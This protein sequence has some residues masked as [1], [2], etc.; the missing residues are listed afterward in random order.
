MSP[1]TAFRLCIWAFTTRGAL[2]LAV[3]FAMPATTFAFQAVA[4]SQ[5]PRGPDLVLANEPLVQIGVF[6]GSPEYI[7]GDVTGAIRLEDGSVVVADEQAH[8]VRRYDAD[9]NHMWTSG[10]E[11]EGPGEYGGLQLLRGCPGSQITVFDWHLDRITELDA[12]GNV[13]AVNSIGARGALPYESPA[14]TPDG[15]LVF[16]PWPDF[17]AVW[18]DLNVDEGTAIDG[19]CH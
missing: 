10:Q 16:T 8:E 13:V 5:A 1:K 3:L 6:D 7:F 9:G 19:Q 12:A 4:E 2:L 14:C 18:E 11:G 15:G 17:A